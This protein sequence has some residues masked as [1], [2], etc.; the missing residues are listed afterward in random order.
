MADFLVSL[1]QPLVLLFAGAILTGLLLPGLARQWQDRQKEIELKTGLVSELSESIVE[2]VMAVQFAHIRSTRKGSRAGNG[3][4]RA[5]QQELDRAYLT[6][7]VRSAVIGTK[8]Q[9][10]FSET[11]IPESWTAFSEIVTDFYALEG[12]NNE[13]AKQELARD[14]R[15]RLSR[16]RGVGGEVGEEW[17]NLKNG[18]LEVKADL[19]DQILRSPIHIFRSSWLPWR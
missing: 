1:A 10:Y 4:V 5:A 9:A 12:V 18:V 13:D 11:T 14:I 17:V 6:W 16:M 8:L 7:E 19:I 2:I 3:D 15:T